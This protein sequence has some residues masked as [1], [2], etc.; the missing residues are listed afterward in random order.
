MMRF[1]V[2]LSEV[3]LDGLR[4]ALGEVVLIR[5]ELITENP[6]DP[7]AFDPENYPKLIESMRQHGIMEPLKVMVDPACE[8]AR[9]GDGNVADVRYVL[10]D[11]YHRWKAATDLGIDE[12]PCE[13]W[14]ISVEEA[15]IRGLQSNYLRGRP[16][17]QRLASVLHDLS[18]TY[19]L[20]D[21]A[22]ML[23]W[24]EAEL[25]DSLEILR[26]PADLDTGCASTGTHGRMIKRPSPL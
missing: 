18:A 22:G 13:V 24:S 2:T 21:L 17:P 8:V 6:W 9:G 19:S 14:E 12:L 3:S 16:V 4:Q 1:V 20:E 5:R 7:N 15:K 23:P 11:G 26:L 10:L 25:K